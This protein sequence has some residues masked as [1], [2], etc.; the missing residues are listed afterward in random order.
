MND[1]RKDNA[2]FSPQALAP[3]HKNLPK[4]SKSVGKTRGE[5]S[6]V[7]IVRFLARQSAEEF[8]EQASAI[9]EAAPAGDET[10]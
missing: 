9:R 5:H 1:H 2:A 6:L 4:S 8:Y 10:S 7:A 3:E